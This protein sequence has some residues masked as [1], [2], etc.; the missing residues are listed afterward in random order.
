[1]SAVLLLLLAVAS[2]QP[3]STDHRPSIIVTYS[4][5]GS[6][7]KELVGDLARVTVSIPNG[8]DPH[9]WEPSAKD[10]E[11]IN[12]A[13]LVVQN[14]LELEGGM[15]KTLAEAE[16]RGVRFFTASDYI[17]VRY[18]GAGEGIPNGG[19]DQQTGA[20][21][22]HIWT[23]PVGMKSVVLALAGVIKSDLDLDVMTGANN[24]SQRL[25]DLDKQIAEMTASVPLDRRKLVTGHESLGYFAR[26]YDFQLIG[27]IVPNLSSEADVSA[28]NLANL[29]KI[30]EANNVNVV[31]TELG[32]PAAVASAISRETGARLVEL[33]THKVP[34]DGSYFTF[35]TNLAQT[36]TDALK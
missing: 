27:A 36:I 4:V 28:A 22:P 9:E 34:A 31:F 23:D 20:P 13:D 6:L 24:L 30:I 2:C 18:V 19:L 29:K 7:V 10:I 11:A 17:D 8:L 32:T 35:M 3:T 1:M 12:R 5:L 15:Q 16:K 14:G 26:R 25:A 33:N 21:D